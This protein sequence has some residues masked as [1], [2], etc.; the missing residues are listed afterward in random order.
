M[1]KLAGVLPAEARI[2]EKIDY[3]SMIRVLTGAWWEC[4]SPDRLPCAL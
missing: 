1:A 4:N 2:L 3:S